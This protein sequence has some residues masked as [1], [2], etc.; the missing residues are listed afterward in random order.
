MGSFLI[1][2]LATLN[3]PQTPP[4]AAPERPVLELK[5][6]TKEGRK[7]AETTPTSTAR[8]V[9]SVGGMLISWSV[10]G[11]E[12][13]VTPPDIAKLGKDR[14]GV[15]IMYPTPNRVRD[16]R[17]TFQ[18]RTFSFT[19]NNKTNFIHGL[20]RGRP[21][22]AGDIKTLTN[23][24]GSV[25][26]E[27]AVW[28]DWNESQPDFA[29]FPLI[30]R[31]TVTYTLSAK[32]LRIAYDVHNT[33][34]DTLPFGFGIHPWFRVP[35]K[36]DDVR[37]FVPTATRM[38]AIE[39][40]PTGRLVPVAESFDLRKPRVLSELNLDDVY[41]PVKSARPAGFELGPEKKRV[42]LTTSADFAHVVVYTPANQ[43]YFCIEN[44]TSSTD[45]HNLWT[46]GFKKESGLRIVA[47]GQHA[48]GFIMFRAE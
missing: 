35:G 27:L 2:L 7:A 23:K 28:I 45:A 41:F 26:S 5:A 10:L 25:S 14:S 16:A 1:L 18:G 42:L 31:L 44:Q 30:H 39:L 29:Q 43:P 17:M 3:A 15:P 20:V 48:T 40:L 47:K 36:R 46:A 9:P 32:N 22:Q 38:E 13:L 4:A 6:W 8:V 12:Y 11:H 19:A 37:L 33:S 21:W 24:D 34:N